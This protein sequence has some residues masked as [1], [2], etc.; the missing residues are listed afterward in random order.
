MAGDLELAAEARHE[1][2][3][4]ERLERA[5]RERAGL[6]L[7]AIEPAD[8]HLVEAGDT[9]VPAAE[10]AKDVVANRARVV[11]GEVDHRLQDLGR[12]GLEVRAGVDFGEVL[13][14]R[15][16]AAFVARALLDQLG[17]GTPQARVARRG[18]E[19][20]RL[21]AALGDVGRA[22]AAGDELAAAV[23]RALHAV[24]QRARSRIVFG[25]LGVDMLDHFPRHAR[26][27]RDA[28]RGEDQSGRGAT[29]ER[30]CAD[31]ESGERAG[32]AEGG[33]KHGGGGAVAAAGERTRDGTSGERS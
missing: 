5:E 31:R 32:E 7:A 12:R 8:E 15:A 20:A 14:R 33:A 11:V 19:R 10:H 23:E 13:E 25:E 4:V 17:Q 2:V 22:N 3:G 24:E 30:G 9:R 18:G 29:G 1:D 6:Q 21:Q 26:V 16:R 28:R 27:G